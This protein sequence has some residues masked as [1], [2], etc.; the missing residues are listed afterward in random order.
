MGDL[1]DAQRSQQNQYEPTQMYHPIPQRPA[2]SHPP[3]GG[4]QASQE[5]QKRNYA[6]T[7]PSM[8]NRPT[9]RRSYGRDGTVLSCKL[10]S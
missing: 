7:M 3:M 1:A 8:R 9:V 2:G 5:L 10:T 4:M 6:P